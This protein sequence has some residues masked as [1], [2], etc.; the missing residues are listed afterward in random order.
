MSQT[1][2]TNGPMGQTWSIGLTTFWVVFFV[3]LYGLYIV[4]F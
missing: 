4:L 1:Y 2:G 3:A